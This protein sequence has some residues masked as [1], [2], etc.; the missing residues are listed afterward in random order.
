MKIIGTSN[1]NSLHQNQEE[2]GVCAVESN[3]TRENS[4][5][6]LL[7]LLIRDPEIMGGEENRIRTHRNYREWMLDGGWI[8]L[9]F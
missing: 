2:N 7:L 5:D 1:S 8:Q 4:I 3:K 9:I 6:L